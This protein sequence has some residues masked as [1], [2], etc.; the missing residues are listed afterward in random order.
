MPC[1]TQNRNENDREEG[2]ISIS[3]SS[4]DAL[5]GL[6]LVDDDDDDDDDDEP[7]LQARTLN[8]RPTVPGAFLELLEQKL[9]ANDV[10]GKDSIC[11]P[12]KQVIENKRECIADRG[13]GSTKHR[14]GWEYIF[15]SRKAR[16]TSFQ[17]DAAIRPDIEQVQS[18]S[19]LPG[20]LLDEEKDDQLKHMLWWKQKRV[21]FLLCAVFILMLVLATGLGVTVQPPS[22]SASNSILGT[23]VPTQAPTGSIPSNKSPPVIT[24]SSEPTASP[25]SFPVSSEPTSAPHVITSNPTPWTPVP[26]KSPYS[27][28]PTYFPT[29]S[30][31]SENWWHWCTFCG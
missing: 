20:A 12:P 11:I 25:S 24:S 30:S 27:S 2:S 17:S 31:S 8:V 29:S 1:S 5:A 26:S 10:A 23:K 9:S 7:P 4:T 16:D 14:R 21:K 3:V 6:E 13:Q 18:G 15:L 19:I 28:E 22:H